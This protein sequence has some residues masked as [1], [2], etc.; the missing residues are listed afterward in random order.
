MAAHN[1][2]PIR[3]EAFSGGKSPLARGVVRPV[4]TFLGR[5]TAAGIL[6]I[7]AT[8]AALIWANVDIDSYHHFWETDISFEVGTFRIHEPLEAWVNDALMALFFFVVGMEIKSELILGDLSNPKI[9][10][11]P[12]IGALGGM[13]VPAGLYF[14]L[15]TS[16]PE[17]AGWGIPM[18]T[19]IAFAVGVLALVGNKVPKQLSLFLLTLAIVDDIGAIVVIAIFYTNDL[20]FTWLGWAVAGLLLVS[21]LQKQ[22]VWFTPVYAV[23]GGFI[24]F[25]TFESG[26]HATIAGVALGLL[27]PARPLLGKAALSHVFERDTVPSVGL[28]KDTQF[29]V[30]EQVGVTSRLITTLS[31][32]TSYLIIPIF[33][34]ANAGIVLNGDV[35]GNA[36]GSSVTWGII[37]GLVVGKP[38]GIYLFSLAALATGVATLPAALRKLH[39]LAAGAVAGI[40][41]TVALFINGLAFSGQ[42]AEEI[43]DQATIGVL[44]ASFLATVV[45]FVIIKAT[46]SEDSTPEGDRKARLVDADA[47]G[48]PDLAVPA[49]RR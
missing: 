28:V 36:L 26:V 45:G 4:A 8:A 19:D 10:A 35:I 12:A 40:G 15:N 31:P 25:A 27:T 17:S 32:F 39:I 9:A 3:D 2:L 38:V 23:I 16:S 37:A 11:L 48:R 49:R 18:A 21:V 30:R 24:W 41:F 5:E 20:S 6:L 44:I 46:G 43:K 13:I 34:L 7:V 29:S 42:A 33:A 22:R 47:D 14:V 1:S